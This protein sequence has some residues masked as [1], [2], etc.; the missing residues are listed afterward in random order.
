MDNSII[1]S[2]EE[3]VELWLYSRPENTI[4][5]YKLH[6]KRFLGSVDK[7]LTEVTLLDLQYWQLSLSGMNKSS[8]K[9]ALAVIKSLFSFGYELG[10][11]KLN[12][13]KLT[14]LPQVKEGLAQK[15]LSTAEVRL[16]IEL[17]INPRNR[18]ILL[19]LYG[20]GLRVSELCSLTWNDLKSRENGGQMTVFGKGGKTRVI[21]IPPYVWETVI[22][23]KNIGGDNPVFRSRQIG[24][25]GYH[26]TR[27]Q[28]ENIVSTASDRAG[29]ERKVSPHWLR[30]SHA[31]HSLDSGA[32]L[33]LVQQT[34]G[35]S[36][37]STTEKYLHAKPDDS[38]GMYIKIFDYSTTN[39]C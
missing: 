3:L 20:C 38:S 24:K 16:M 15:I 12:I 6:V 17:E 19:M 13:A 25:N 5:S 28:V 30:H 4:A 1:I 10:V 33:S 23:L 29:I 11:L 7:P 18:A 39:Q 27:K 2:N 32:P 36:S 26:L 8:Q 9:T 34:L 37:I 35:H 14:K 21:L 22:I 31:S